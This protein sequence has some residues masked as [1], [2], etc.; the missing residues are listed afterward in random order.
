MGRPKKEKPN[1]QGLY[2]VKVT[3][4]KNFDGTLIRKSFYSTISKADAKAKAEQYKINQALQE[5]TGENYNVAPIFSKVANEF[6]ELKKGTIKNSTYN[7]TYFIPADKYLIPYFGNRRISDIRKNDIELYLKKIKKQYDFSTET[8]RKHYICLNQ[9]FKNAYENGIIN[10]NPCTGIKLQNVQ[11]SS[12]RV[13]T[14]EESELVLEY[15]PYHRY[16]LSV[17]LMLSYGISRSELLGIR[18]KDVDLENSVIEINQGVV[19]AKNPDTGKTELV[20]GAPKNEFRQR[21]I[22][23]S[24]ET[25]HLLMQQIYNFP[26]A[27]YVICNQH[28]KVCTPS[29]W[30]ERHYK[31]FMQDM[32]EYYDNYDI[33]IPMLNPH[34]LRHTRTS[35]WVNSD[36][37]LYAVASVMGWADL[38]MLRKRY[39]HPDIDKI[40]NAIK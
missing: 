5:V 32:K 37:N 6:L 12:K 28:G 18:W 35:L 3:I 7:F 15:C 2:E 16:G 27:E 21:T 13:Y 25:M 23:I 39:A 30:H 14:P 31:V 9:I 40:R 29:T 19:E 10:R 38:K 26:D 36:V 8:V 1:K 20:I 33:E 11:K 34:E 22:P 24:A 4:G 17:H